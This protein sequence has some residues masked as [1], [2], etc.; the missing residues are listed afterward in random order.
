MEEYP[1]ANRFAG[2]RFCLRGQFWRRPKLWSAELQLAYKPAFVRNLTLGLNAGGGRSVITRSD[3]PSAAAVGEHTLFTPKW[4]ATATADYRLNIT[5]SLTGVV[6]TD[7]DYTGM[8]YGSFQS[9]DPGYI[10]PSYGVVN[11]SIGID[12]GS[13]QVSLYGKNLET[14]TPSFS[15]PMWPRSTKAMPCGR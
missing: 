4:T 10:N 2:L 14:I 15:D 12:T 8:S 1:A 6:R 13:F 11:G 3:D 7:Y 9:A 5:D